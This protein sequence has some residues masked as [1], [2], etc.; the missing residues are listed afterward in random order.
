MVFMVQTRPRPRT[1]KIEQTSRAVETTMSNTVEDS[2]FLKTLRAFFNLKGDKLE[3]RSPVDTAQESVVG[4]ASSFVKPASEIFISISRPSSF[5]H[6]GHAKDAIEAYAMFS[7]SAAMRTNRVGDPGESPGAVDLDAR[8]DLDG[9]LATTH[10]GTFLYRPDIPCKTHLR[11]PNKFKPSMETIEKTAS[12]KVYFETYFNNLLKRPSRRSDRS[13]ELNALLLCCAS[14]AEQEHLQEE[15]SRLESEH[16]RALRRKI[17]VS[18]FKRLK[19]I[20]HGAFGVVRLVQER[21]SG[22]IYAMKCLRKVDMLRKG[23]EGHVRAERDVLARASDSG[24][25]IAK[26]EYSFQD[27]EFLYL[28]MEYMPGGDLLQLLIHQNVFSERF[29]RFYLAQMVNA[30]EEAHKLGYIHRDIK[31]DNFLFNAEGHIRLSDFG[32]ST[33]L[34]WDHDSHYFDQ[35]RSDLLRRTGIDIIQGDTLDRRQGGQISQVLKDSERVP[36]THQMTWRNDRRRS[37]AYSLVGTNSYMAPEVIGG[38][39]YGFSCGMRPFLV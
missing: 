18:S 19:V 15:W 12:T 9:K 28:V 21:R 20:G 23:Q 16:L 3:R 38:E 39:G 6:I 5:Q 10:Q 11:L 35:Q 22:M 17:D 32:L 13:S 27:S 33:D 24:R 36:T 29:A 4:P 14:K 25:Y 8:T 1:V 26:L 34:N 37:L 2:S 30:I 7:D 31:P